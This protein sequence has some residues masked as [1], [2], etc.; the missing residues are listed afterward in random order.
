LEPFPANDGNSQ[1]QM[2]WC[3]LKQC[4]T[5]ARISHKI[6]AFFDVWRFFEDYIVPSACMQRFGYEP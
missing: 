6:R 5:E 2:F 1:L 3:N 4:M